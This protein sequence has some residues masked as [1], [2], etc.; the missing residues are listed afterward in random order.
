MDKW[1]N[2]LIKL[3]A[4]DSGRSAFVDLLTIP[5]PSEQ[6]PVVQFTGIYDAIGREIW[7]GDILYWYYYDEREQAGYE[8]W[9]QVVFHKGGFGTMNS[10]GDDFDPFCNLNSGDLVVGNIFANA[11]LIA[12][13]TL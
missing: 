8:A 7:E 10:T 3:R 13:K 2:R 4:W 5:G 9:Y 1:A 12:T 11:D 6:R